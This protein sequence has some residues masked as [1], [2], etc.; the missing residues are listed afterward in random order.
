MKCDQDVIVYQVNEDQCHELGAD[1]Q[2]KGHHINIKFEFSHHLDLPRLIK[3]EV[4]ICVNLVYSDK[5]N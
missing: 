1:D 3:Y 5:T 2:M 4:V